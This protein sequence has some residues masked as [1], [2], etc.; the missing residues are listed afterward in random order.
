MVRKKTF[1]S[2]VKTTQPIIVKPSDSDAAVA[3]KEEMMSKANK[4]LKKANVRN[5]RVT[6][7]GT[8]VVEVSSENDR[9][10]AIS[11]FKEGFSHSYVVEGAKII[12]PK[13]TVVGTPP[14]IPGDEIISVYR[15][16]DEKLNQLVESGKTLEV[17]KCFDVKKQ[18]WRYSTEKS[19]Y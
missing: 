4:A 14:D 11:R 8:L 9:E 18:R 15:E 17:V 13:L 19:C 12:L 6:N 2:I 5:G 3:R 10:G 16:K 1:A 7:K